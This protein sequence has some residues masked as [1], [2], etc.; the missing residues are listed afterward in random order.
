M[1]IATFL[2]VT[3]YVLIAKKSVINSFSTM[4]LWCLY[5]RH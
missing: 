1:L 3:K 4:W 5:G 2:N